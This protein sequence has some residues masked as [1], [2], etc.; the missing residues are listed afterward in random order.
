[1]VKE[2]CSV[3]ERVSQAIGS[4]WAILLWQDKK[5]QHADHAAGSFKGPLQLHLQLKKYIGKR[6]LEKGSILN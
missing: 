2:E 5:T 1:M 6:L 4:M 3:R